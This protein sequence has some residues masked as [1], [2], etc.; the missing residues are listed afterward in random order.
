MCRKLLA[1]TVIIRIPAEG[2]QVRGVKFAG[3]LDESGPSE[4]RCDMKP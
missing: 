3:S 2:V 1:R 4:M